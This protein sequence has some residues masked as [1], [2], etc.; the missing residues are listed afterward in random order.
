LS[1]SLIALISTFGRHDI[2]ICWLLAH[3]L[4]ILLIPRDDFTAIVL[5]IPLIRE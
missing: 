4:N 1:S 3:F 2:R 5:F